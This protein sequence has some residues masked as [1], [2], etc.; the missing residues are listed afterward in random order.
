M[1]QPYVAVDPMI[2]ESRNY[3]PLK[4]LKRKVCIRIEKIN[5]NNRKKPLL[6]VKDYTFAQTTSDHRYWNCSRK[7]SS[8]CNAKLRFND[9]G[10]LIH[11][12]LDHSHSPPV[13]Y[14]KHDVLEHLSENIVKPMKAEFK[15]KLN[16]LVGRKKSNS[17]YLIDTA[18]YQDFIREVKEIKQKWRKTFEDYKML[19]NY[20]ILVV[21]DRE[22]LI[23]PRNESNPSIKFYVSIDDLFGNFRF[24]SEAFFI[25]SL[26]GKPLIVFKKYTYCRHSTRNG[27]VRWTCSTHSYKCCKA[28]VKTVGKHIIE[29]KGCHNHDADA[30]QINRSKP[31]FDWGLALVQENSI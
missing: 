16:R 23:Q 12:D 15:E 3:N 26:R 7:A 9:A 5:V 18:R 6:L 4:G 30:L 20:D 2:T 17:A 31:I 27:V 1:Q 11:C 22:R 13:F 10:K 28:V 8:K 29:V 25:Q 24:G 21:N 14:R 19:A